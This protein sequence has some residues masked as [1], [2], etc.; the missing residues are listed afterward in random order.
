MKSM[1]N[2]RL[3][4]RGQLK[5]GSCLVG[6]YLRENLVDLVDVTKRVKASVSTAAYAFRQALAT[7]IK[8]TPV[9]ANAIGHMSNVKPKNNQKG[10]N[11][12]NLF[13]IRPLGVVSKKLIGDLKIA[14]AI[15]SWS[16]REAC[17]NPHRACVS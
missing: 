6:M 2:V 14:N 15:L 4:N 10:T 13:R 7:W 12:E 1:L 8:Q 5:P 16:F 17:V 11:L 3:H 9:N